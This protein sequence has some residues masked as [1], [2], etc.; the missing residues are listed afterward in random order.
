MSKK[1]LLIVGSGPGGIG[2]AVADHIDRSWTRDDYDVLRPNSYAGG[3]DNFLELD[4]A[5]EASIYD[6]IA[7][8]GPIDA[9]V[10]CAGTNTPRYHTNDTMAAQVYDMKVNAFGFASILSAHARLYGENRIASSVAIVSDAARIP[11]RGSVSYCASKAAL[12]QIIRVAARE[13]MPHSRINGVAP[14]SVAGSRMT[15]QAGADFAD[16]RGFTA[17]Q[18]ASYEM[19]G[20]PMGRKVTPKEVAEVVISVLFGPEYMNGTI[21]D[22]TGGK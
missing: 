19:A 11:M 16:M 15:A 8:V 4:V 18:A 5:D 2:E 21:V 17:E 9:L 13:S 7:K 22:I 1:K 3:D 12:A 14:T 6:Y 10:Y 20:L